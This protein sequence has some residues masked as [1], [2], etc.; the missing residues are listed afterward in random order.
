MSNLSRIQL[1]CVP[2]LARG[3]SIEN[4]AAANNISRRTIERWFKEKA[5]REFLKAAITQRLD[6][7]L[8]DNASSLGELGPLSIDALKRVLSDP[9]ATVENVLRASDIVQRA[10]PRITEHRDR[11]V[12]YKRN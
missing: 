2:G 9:R 5:F 4:I 6:R 7:A 12:K 11:H 3:D 10:I 1:A 8:E